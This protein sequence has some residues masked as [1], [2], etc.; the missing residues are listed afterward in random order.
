MVLT[1]IIFAGINLGKSFGY[2]QTIA[3]ITKLSSLPGTKN[4]ESL[5]QYYFQMQCCNENFLY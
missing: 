4:N 3:D 1:L 2:R 5:K